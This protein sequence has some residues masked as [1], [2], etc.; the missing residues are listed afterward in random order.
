LVDLE[1]SSLSFVNTDNYDKE[2]NLLKKRLSM[3]DIGS[4]AEI[5]P[6]M[7]AAP[8]PSFA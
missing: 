6:V 2:K 3:A 5:T 4:S 7:P 8:I 1:N